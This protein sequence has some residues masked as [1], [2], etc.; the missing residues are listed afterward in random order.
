MNGF[1]LA[2]VAAFLFGLSTPASKLLLES[3]EP[4]QLAGLLYLGA[5][6][7][8]LPIVLME[9]RGGARLHLARARARSRSARSGYGDRGPESVASG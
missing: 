8:T 6:V 7:G 2:A 9:R 4:F 1:V 5:A 3:F